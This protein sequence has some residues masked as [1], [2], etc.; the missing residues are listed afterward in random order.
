VPPGT[1]PP[2]TVPFVAWPQP[3]RAKVIAPR[4]TATGLE[5]T[6]RRYAAGRS[7]GHTLQGIFPHIGPGDGP[8]GAREPVNRRASVAA[9]RKEPSLRG[10][11]SISSPLFGLRHGTRP[12]G[13]SMSREQETPALNVNRGA[14]GRPVPSTATTAALRAPSAC[15]WRS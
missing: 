10:G 13:D 1:I 7:S 4:A 6:S 8:I 12:R 5:A 11:G 14:A 9:P 15:R 3:A 2:V